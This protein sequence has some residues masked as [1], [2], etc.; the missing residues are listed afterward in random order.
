MKLGKVMLAAVL[1]AG[2]GAAPALAGSKFKVGYIDIQKVLNGSRAGLEAKQILTDESEERK[3]ILEQQ[4]RDLKSL[5]EELERKGS[6]LSSEA[7][8]KKEDEFRAKQ[9]EFRNLLTKMELELQQK[10]LELTQSILKDLEGII[11]GV[12]KKG[13]YDLILEKNEGMVLYAPDDF[14]LSE[15]VI[16]L[17]DEEKKAKKD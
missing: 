5:K 4:D 13:D 7:R 9:S 17:Y 14:D 8:A 11:E 10:D 12:G 6:A 1:M 2:F 15:Q 16:R 3:K